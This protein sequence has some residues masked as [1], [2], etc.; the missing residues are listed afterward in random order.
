[1]TQLKEILYLQNDLWAI[2]VYSVTAAK[3]VSEKPK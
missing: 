1:M 2:Q 3:P